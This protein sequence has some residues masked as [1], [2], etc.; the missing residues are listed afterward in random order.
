MLETIGKSKLKY[1]KRADNHPIEM[2]RYEGDVDVL[3]KK[4]KLEIYGPLENIT[5]LIR[6]E[7]GD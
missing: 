1:I 2:P 6:R 4:I 5:V 3:G 7:I